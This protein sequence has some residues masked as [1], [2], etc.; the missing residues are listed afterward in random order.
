MLGSA[1]FKIIT[2]QFKVEQK[3][4]EAEIWKEVRE[5]QTEQITNFES[6]KS[7]TL[8]KCKAIQLEAEKNVLDTEKV[9]QKERSELYEQEQLNIERKFEGRVEV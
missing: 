2:S 5:I 7:E 9:K 8:E 1:G 4:R 6:R 3:D